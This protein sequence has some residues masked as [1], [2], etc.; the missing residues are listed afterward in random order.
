MI[1]KTHFKLSIQISEELR[2]IISQGSSN[3]STDYQDAL[4][5]V[6]LLTRFVPYLM[7]DQSDNFFDSVFWSNQLPPAKK[8]LSGTGTTS[9]KPKEEAGEK[10]A[11]ESVDKGKDKVEDV[12]EEEGEPAKEEV[13][14]IAT[15]VTERQSKTED[16]PIGIHILN[17]CVNLLFY[18]GF[19]VSPLPKEPSIPPTSLPLEQVW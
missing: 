2:R 18:P 4:N 5:C 6:R 12:I 11:T 15:P 16:G 14:V 10:T 17:S 8:E 13:Q 19:T 1:V 7:E 9:E 3:T